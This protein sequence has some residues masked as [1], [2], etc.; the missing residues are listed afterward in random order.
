M[1]LGLILF[2]LI[3]IY[4]LGAS[5]TEC[6]YQV[7]NPSTSQILEQG[8]VPV[9]RRGSPGTP[10][11]F[12]KKL[13]SVGGSKIFIEGNI[14]EAYEDMPASAFLWVMHDETLGITIYAPSLVLSRSQ[15]LLHIETRNYKLHVDCN[16]PSK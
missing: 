3:N 8:A 16:V 15:T 6:T 14:S 7:L 12:S 2:T 13:S 4:V 5:A 11:V 10:T 9:I 1:K